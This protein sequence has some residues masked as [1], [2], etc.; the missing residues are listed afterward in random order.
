VTESLDTCDGLPAD[1]PASAGAD[2]P[3]DVPALKMFYL[4][5]SAG[6]NLH[7]R[8]CW[9]TPTFV[10]GQPVPGESLDFELLKGAVA[11]A[12]PMGLSAAKLTGGEPVLHPRFLEIVDFLTAEG[13]D[14]SMETNGTLIDRDMAVHLYEKTNL[15]RV[16]VSLDSPDPAEHDRFRGLK[17]AFDGAVRGIRH[18]AAAGI[19]P[20]IIMSVYRGNTG[21][22]EGL[23]ELA[24]QLGAG[25]VK[26]NPV[27]QSGRGADIHRQGHGLDF[28]EW[29]GLI[30]RI[31]G[32]LQ[33]R[34]PIHL[35]AMV[36]SA[37]ST[38]KELLRY[39]GEGAG[40]QVRHILGLLGTGEMAL[41]G[42]G[43]NI[44]ELCF[45]RLGQDSLRE[46]WMTHPVLVQMRK[47]LAGPYP[48]I[49]GDCLHAGRC[50]THCL[51]QNYEANGRL[52]SPSP[53][54][55]EAERRGVFPPTRRISYGG[56][57]PR[58]PRSEVRGPKSEDPTS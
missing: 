12:K 41:C 4:Y 50:M 54:C 7:C 8:H 11:E 17:G 14:L 49:C 53:L 30:H 46:V 52:V 1:T 43:R 22:V 51:A 44:P 16:S 33:D 23:I 45:G 48:G 28:D 35:G 55:A 15:K 38:A 37:L 18:L 20:Q 26:F 47:D 24:M 36:P 5:L 25:S 39:A 56:K 58:G 9:I 29:M 32:P 2:M 3:P 21:R 13:L 6:C 42:I 34:Y 31:R 57:T 19:P 40:C 10:H 27:T